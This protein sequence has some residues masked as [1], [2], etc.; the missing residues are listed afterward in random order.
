MLSSILN[1]KNNKSLKNKKNI[2]E[3]DLLLHLASNIKVSISI[4]PSLQLKMKITCLNWNMFGTMLLRIEA[5]EA[6][7]LGE[8]IIKDSRIRIYIMIQSLIEVE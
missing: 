8:L 6:F 3:G 4:G 5:L 2:L 7:N 1:L